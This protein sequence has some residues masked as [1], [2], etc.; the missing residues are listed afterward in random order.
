[1][2]RLR[3]DWRRKRLGIPA[4]RMAL[5]T[6]IAEL[7]DQ[8]ANIHYITLDATETMYAAMKEDP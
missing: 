8:H 2:V 3:S 6:G 1:M 4:D 5:R 7:E